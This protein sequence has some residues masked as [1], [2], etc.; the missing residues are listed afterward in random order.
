MCPIYYFRE[1]ARG[2]VKNENVLL[3]DILTQ[4]RLPA[5]VIP[6]VIQV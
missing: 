3:G 2:V 6:S 5:D 4:I 1:F